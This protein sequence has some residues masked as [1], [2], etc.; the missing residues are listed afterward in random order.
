LN[1]ELILASGESETRYALDPGEV[2]RIGRTAENTIVLRSENVSR[3]HAI[4]LTN[5]SSVF[6]LYDLG[7]RN[8]TYLNGSRIASPT[9]L[10][11]GDLI[12][13]GGLELRFFQ[14]GTQSEREDGLSSP[15]ATIVDSF[16]S[17]ISVIVM[18][19]RGYTDLCRRIGDAHVAEI[20]QSFNS[21]AGAA[22]AALNARS[23]KYIGDTVMA[24]WVHRGSPAPFLMAALRGISTLLEIAERLQPRFG[25]DSPV[26]FGA[27]ANMGMASIGNMGSTVAPDYTAL[28]DAVNKAFRLEASTRE[29]QADV[30]ISSEVYEALRSVA[31][32]QGSLSAHKVHLKGYSEGALVYAMNRETLRNVLESL[33]TKC[34]P[35]PPNMETRRKIPDTN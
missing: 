31:D 26:I 5:E 34:A 1:A 4:V 17:V 7:S 11:D 30:I 18:D 3:K 15:L 6:V 10:R 25:L 33:G 24:F 8:G 20:M 16:V 12:S 2:C 27:A 32:L 35:K 19:I 14:S 13:I 21:E 29:L 9:V 28:G 22:L 23:V